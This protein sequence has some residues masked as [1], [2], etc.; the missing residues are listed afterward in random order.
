[1][2]YIKS[3]K[4]IIPWLQL[5]LFLLVT[6]VWIVWVPWGV[7]KSV[8]WILLLLI[9]PLSL[10]SFVIL[11]LYKWLPN[12]QRRQVRAWRVLY[13][14]VKAF[15]VIVLPFSLLREF[16]DF[17]RE[18]TSILPPLVFAALWILYT[19]MLLKAPLEKLWPEQVQNS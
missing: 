17:P 16:L 12:R 19:I 4:N 5:V 8:G 3:L 7:P 2:P 6:A 10:L 1:M 14:G 11:P 13:A 9:T 18:L 15:M